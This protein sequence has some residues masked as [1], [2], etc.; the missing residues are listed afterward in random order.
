MS[1][2]SKGL[3]A[4]MEDETQAA[5][6]AI[7]QTGADSAEA[8]IVEATDISADV[9]AG[10]AEIDQAT[11][12]AETL[13]RIADTAEAAEAEGGLDPVAAEVA[14]IAVESIYAR[15]GVTRSSYPALESFSGR[16][17]RKRATQLA[18]EDI[19][20]TVKK[21]WA[22]IVNAF[23]KIIDFVKNFFGKMF[24]ANKKLKARI[25]AL[26]QK[27]S[28]AKEDY[29]GKVKASG[30]SKAF[31]SSEKSGILEAASSAA[32][33]LG[34]LQHWGV[35]A[36]AGLGKIS[37]DLSR[38]LAIQRSGNDTTALDE[39]KTIQDFYKEAV[40][41]KSVALN[42]KQII[43]PRIEVQVEANKGAGKAAWE[44]I[45][46]F[47]AT[48]KDNI[49]FTEKEELEALNRKEVS[50]ILASADDIIDVNL[51]Q[52][53]VVAD[54]E[55]NVTKVINT[56][57]K[58]QSMVPV[59]DKDAGTLANDSRIGQRAIQNAGNTIVKVVTAGGKIGMNC[60]K[61][62]IDYAERSMNAK[63][64]SDDSSSKDDKKK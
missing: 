17:G 20:E 23:Q 26:N 30:I 45:S 29:T 54:I 35:K 38:V 14:E 5:E 50:A 21:I 62:A 6:L 42:S 47:G 28:S 13:T 61:A 36:S 58:M 12:D 27:N 7:D 49:P 41:L 48:I 2:F 40:N 16:T 57:K 4:A 64:G 25:N 37:E 51:S 18:I 46:S 55:A 59:D 32:E 15:L 31:G 11:A 10:T 9:E 43:G 44:A 22:A 52:K 19:K 24:D 34:V 33:E 56:A 39:A 8:D 3:V 1:I 63:G 53:A 60:A